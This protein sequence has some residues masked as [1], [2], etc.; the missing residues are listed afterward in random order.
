MTVWSHSLRNPQD[1]YRASSSYGIGND[2]HLQT[3]SGLYRVVIETSNFAKDAAVH[4]TI[5]QERVP[6]FLGL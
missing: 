5:L 6:V 3:D 2:A 1:N 4:H